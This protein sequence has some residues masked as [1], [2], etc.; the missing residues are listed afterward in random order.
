VHFY[1]WSQRRRLRKQ[2]SVVG[3][4]EY[5]QCVYATRE[6]IVASRR[7]VDMIVAAKQEKDL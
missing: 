1:A 4:A 7:A 5:N 6:I 3:G 2:V